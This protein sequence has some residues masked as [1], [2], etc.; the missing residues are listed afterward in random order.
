MSVAPGPWLQPAASNSGADPWS[1]AD[2]LVGLRRI[3]TTS[4]SGSGGTR[5]DQGVRPT[6]KELRKIAEARANAGE[7]IGIVIGQRKER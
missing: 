2:A 1:A 3:C 4:D 7:A 6:K 5:A